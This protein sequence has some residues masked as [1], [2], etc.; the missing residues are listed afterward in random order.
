MSDKK[1]D[2]LDNHHP[3]CPGPCGQL[4]DEC[5][6]NIN[7][8]KPHEH[9]FVTT[10]YD[11]YELRCSD[12]NCFT[13]KI[14]PGNPRFCPDGLEGIAHEPHEHTYTYFRYKEKTATT[15]SVWCWG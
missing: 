2:D 10:K 1:T 14:L 15:G 7:P 13:A 8:P 3:T 5:M 9:D 12:P 4:A 6:C 11:D